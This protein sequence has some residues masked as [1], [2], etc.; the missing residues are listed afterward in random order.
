MGESIFV[1]INEI[2]LQAEKES[3]KII[4]LKQ[5]KESDTSLTMVIGELEF[6]AIAKEKN[7]IQTPRP[8]THELYLNI[9]A[10]AGIEFRRVEIYDL[11]EQSFFARVLYQKEGTETI[12]DARPS[13]AIAL[14]LN[15]HLPIWVH[16]KLLRK[17]L[18]PE[19]VEVYKD[20]IKTVK[21]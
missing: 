9:L 2:I 15:R 16:S 7:M 11:R 20:F 18:S 8:L 5:N 19:Q 17:E 21:F 6:L 13:D 4:I 3:G 10:E 14:A 1:V 12:A